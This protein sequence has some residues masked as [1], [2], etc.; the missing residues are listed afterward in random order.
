MTRLTWPA[1]TEN[2]RNSIERLRAMMDEMNLE[3]FNPNFKM[4]ESVPKSALPAYA[5]RNDK[6]TY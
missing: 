6:L 4:I 5:P 2:Q 3:S 1:M